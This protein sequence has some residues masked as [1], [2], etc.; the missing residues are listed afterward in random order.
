[1]YAQAHTHTH[2][3]AHKIIAP[4]MMFSGTLK[5]YCSHLQKN[6]SCNHNIALTS[7]EKHSSLIQGHWPV[8]RCGQ[9]VN[10][11]TAPFRKSHWERN[12]VATTCLMTQGIE[13]INV[14]PGA[15]G[16]RTA[17]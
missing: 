3:H 17:P 4:L 5:F 16:T 13:M 9:N 14:V 2:T 8:T 15:R 10:Q 7:V 12:R 1:M 11:G 6:G